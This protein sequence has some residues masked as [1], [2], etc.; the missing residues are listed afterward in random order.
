MFAQGMK[1]QSKPLCYEGK[2]RST[3]PEVSFNFR[4]GVLHGILHSM[5][6]RSRLAQNGMLCR[7]VYVAALT[8]HKTTPSQGCNKM[9][10]KSAMVPAW[11]CVTPASLVRG[12]GG[13]VRASLYY[14]LAVAAWKT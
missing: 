11:I 4:Y 1:Q 3:V 8:R 6:L 14:T 7:A 10:K 13:R 12:M 9:W 2:W 5:S